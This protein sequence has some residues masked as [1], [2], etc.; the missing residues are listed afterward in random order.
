MSAPLDLQDLEV[1]ARAG[2]DRVLA[3][4]QAMVRI[5]TQTPPSDTRAMV[6]LVA[7]WL[8]EIPDVSVTRYVSE[9][10][11]E[12]L[13]ARLD[14]GLPGK[15]LI[16][17]GHLDTYP[18]GRTE[19]WTQDPL[20]GAVIKGRL[21]G[22][23]SADMKGANAALIECFRIFAER[24]RPFPG[25]I[26]L[27]LGG[28]EERMGELGAQWLIDHVP[29][30]RGDGVIVADV[31]GPRAVRLGE[32]GMLWLRLEAIGRQ[33]HG[34]HVHSGENAVDRLIDA[35]VD[36]RQL[37][38][39]MPKPEV[40]AL[41]V[42]EAA[43]GIAGA[44]GPIS[45]QTMQ[46]IT[47]N[48]GKIEGGSSS[49]LVPSKASA[50][51]DIRIPLGLAADEVEEAAAAL[52]RRHSSVTSTTER[53]YEPTWTNAASPVA[54]ACLS[55]VGGVMD[56]QAWFD[57]RIGGS[58]ARLWRRAGF[59]TVVLGLTPHNLGAPDEH[60]MIQELGPLTAIYCVAVQRFL[61]D[62]P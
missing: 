7:G 49:N 56:A 35:L 27:V 12:N 24:M 57:M 37:E 9:H 32:K 40:E 10:P 61:C 3:M 21:Y 16:L 62:Y 38:T 17:N 25:E 60:L 19:D 58:D 2:A 15:R 55:A 6:D 59:E 43:A 33:A 39:L 11:I 30:V 36:L 47:V 4:T 18:I 29:E 44:D 8:A 23:G 20:G 1:L 54:Q 31:G 14:G 13:V 51:L 34:A 28:D 53:L 48:L 46:R 50:G 22:R 45:R 41:N 26:V 52:L 5:D 42:I